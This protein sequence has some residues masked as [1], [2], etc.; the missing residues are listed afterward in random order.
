VTGRLSSSGPNLQNIPVRH[1]YGT[2]VRD[3]FRGQF[4][5]GD[6]DALEMRIMAHF[7]RDPEL[8]RIFREGLDPHARTAY[9][10]FGVEVDHEDERRGIGKTV[11]Y[12]VGYGAGAKKLAQVLSL[13]GYATTIEVAKGYLAEVRGFYPTFFRWG[14]R[15]K[16]HA[17]TYGGVDTIAG[18]RRHL[19]GQ[20]L[21]VSSWKKLMYG[22]RQ[23]V[24]SII[25]GSAA[26]IIRRGM[27]QVRLRFPELRT[28]AQ[29]HDEAIW[30]YDALPTVGMRRS[31][32]HFMEVGHGF[33]LA[34]PLIFEPMVCESW[35]QKGSGSTAIELLEEEAMKK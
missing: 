24:N 13:E 17:K 20:F 5:I 1:E 6:Y 27:V 28:L 29:I 32:Q 10:L 21:E 35:A 18:R 34:V 7:S 22:E 16:Y 8:M 2:M 31:I 3:L 14:D 23:A 19:K 11:N 30:E 15:K 4:I 25:Q 26:D 9:A 33:K 12:G